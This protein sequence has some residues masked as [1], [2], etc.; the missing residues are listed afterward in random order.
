MSD[1]PFTLDNCTYR[2]GETPAF[3]ML[4]SPDKL[5]FPILS[6]TKD[7]TPY[8]HTIDGR[9]HACSSGFVHYDLVL[10]PKERHWSKPEDVPP[11]VVWLGA[12]LSGDLVLQ[13]YDYGVR[14]YGRLWSWD[15]FQKYNVHWSHDRRNWKPCKVRE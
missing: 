1:C 6:V 10:K 15:D 3:I 8:Y 9:L 13:V 7:G 14:T 2:N 12:D 4:R 5:N 11:G